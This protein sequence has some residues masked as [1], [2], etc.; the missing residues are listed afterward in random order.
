ME[1]FFAKS[2]HTCSVG[3]NTEKSCTSESITGKE[4]KSRPSVKEFDTHVVEDAPEEE[5]HPNIGST[6]TQANVAVSD[7]YDIGRA[8][9]KTKRGVQLTNNEREAYLSER[10]VPRRRDEYPFSEKKKPK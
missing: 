9:K 5:T 2:S 10:W 7:R 4:H 1:S 6:A 8:V 3:S